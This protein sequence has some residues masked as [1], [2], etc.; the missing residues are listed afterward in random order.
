MTKKFLSPKERMAK[1]Q[2]KTVL[3]KGENH[4]E[5]NGIEYKNVEEYLKEL[6]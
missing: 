1:L 2:K 5:P 4:T 3:Y 6:A